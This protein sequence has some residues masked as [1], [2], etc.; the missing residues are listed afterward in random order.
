MELVITDTN[1]RED[2]RETVSDSWSKLSRK[3]L[4][5]NIM[6]PDGPISSQTLSVEGVLTV[7]K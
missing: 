3:G 2:L 6:I 5:Q 7:I 4:S 1:A